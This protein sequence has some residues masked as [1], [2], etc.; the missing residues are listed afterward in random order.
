MDIPAQE[1]DHYNHASVGGWFPKLACLVGAKKTTY[2]P[3]GTKTKIIP[4]GTIPPHPVGIILADS[5]NSRPGLSTA[6]DR[7]GLPPSIPR[8]TPTGIMHCTKHR[9]GLPPS[10]P[11][12][13]PTGI[14]L[15]P[16]GTTCPP[17]SPPFLL[18][19]LGCHL[20]RASPTSSFAWSH[21]ATFENSK[22]G[23]FSY[24]SMRTKSNP[25]RVSCINLWYRSVLSS[26][27]FLPRPGL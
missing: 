23:S 5:S 19:P 14:L 25:G 15:V 13:A 9:P 8:I 3:V 22:T 4:V 10:I 6:Q 11:L 26:V 16:T 12:I 7:P 24:P 1:S 18:S 20:Y 27:V 17:T 21:F 2:T